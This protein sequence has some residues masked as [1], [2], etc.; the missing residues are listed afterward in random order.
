M[1][2]FEAAAGW[3][4]YPYVWGCEFLS[5][6]AWWCSPGVVPDR[7]EPVSFVDTERQLEDWIEADPSLVGDGLVI[8]GRQVQFDGGPADLLAIDP[9]GRWVII[10]IKRGRNVRQDLAQAIDYGSSLA[11]EPPDSLRSRLASGLRTKPYRDAALGA[12]EAALTDEGPLPREVAYLLT[13]VGVHEATQRMQQYLIHGG[14]DVRVVTLEAHRAPDGRMVLLREPGQGVPEESQAPAQSNSLSWQ[15]GIERIRAV[16]AECEVLP[17]FDRWLTA[18]THAGL[19]TR[20]Y[21][22]SIMVGPPTHKNAYLMVG[23]PVTGG[24]IRLNHG[25][26]QSAQWFPWIPEES[27]TEILGS[28]TRGMGAVFSGADLDNYIVRVEDFL[29]AYFPPPEEFESFMEQHPWDRDR[30]IAAFTNRPDLQSKVLRILD[31]AE[32][33]Y[34]AGAVGQAHLCF[35]E[36]GP[37]ILQIS[38][39]GW[40]RGMWSLGTVDATSPQWRPLKDELASWGGLG[41]DDQAPRISLDELSNETIERI[42]NISAEVSQSLAPSRDQ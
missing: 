24:G 16:A 38:T 13:G 22:H 36:G 12:I 5:S 8:V 19:A 18:A 34:G 32:V 7:L 35:D 1:A 2:R 33:S 6:L 11:Y 28:S 41:P 23:R 42:L 40:L 21:K 14:M 31:S 39:A 20:P 25:A 3:S 37:Q 15:E 27:V 9:Q 17:E 30:F 4:R 29:S 10:E 26:A